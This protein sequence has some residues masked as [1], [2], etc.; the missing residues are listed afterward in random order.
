MSR[1]VMTSG[2]DWTIVRFLQ[3]KAGPAKGTVRHGFYGTD[4]LG[5]GVTRADIATFTAGQV[6]DPRYIG[7]APGHKQLILTRLLDDL[8]D[9]LTLSD[10]R[11]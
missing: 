1:I 9:V 4:D 3:P 11:I 10:V 5:F 8:R 6:D 2:P 7:A